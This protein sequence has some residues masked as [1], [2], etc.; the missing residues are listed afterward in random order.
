M[1][2]VLAWRLSVKLGG[3][4]EGDRIGWFGD[5]TGQ[6]DVVWEDRSWAGGKGEGGV[7]AAC[8]GHPG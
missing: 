5:L 7:A 8:I 1:V 2:D 6:N 3:N 4:E